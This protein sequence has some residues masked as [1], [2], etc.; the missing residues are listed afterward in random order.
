MGVIISYAFSPL[1]A[2]SGGQKTN[3]SG[4]AGEPFLQLQLLLLAGPSMEQ[5]VRMCFGIMRRS[6]KSYDGSSIEDGK[7]GTKKKTGLAACSLA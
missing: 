1:F 3:P 7:N 4:V 6:K 2:I 5:S